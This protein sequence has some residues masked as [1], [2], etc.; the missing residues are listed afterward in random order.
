MPMRDG[1]YL[2][3]MALYARGMQDLDA[4]AMFT[5]DILSVI[6][7]ENWEL[8]ETLTPEDC[9][10]GD[11]AHYQVYWNYLKNGYEL[12]EYQDYEAMLDAVVAHF[13]QFRYDWI[14]RTEYS[15]EG[16]DEMRSRTVTDYTGSIWYGGKPLRG[17]ESYLKYAVMTRQAMELKREMTICGILEE[18]S[19]DWDTGT[20]EM[21]TALVN[22]ETGQAFLEEGLYHLEPIQKAEYEVPQYLS[23]LSKGV[24]V[25]PTKIPFGIIVFIAAWSLPD[26]VR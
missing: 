22:A 4:P 17:L 16:D 5:G 8:K 14:S 20:Y 12:Q 19:S 10:N 15:G 18:Y 2:W 9:P 23:F 7:D 25:K 1:K 11:K 24:P 26:C 3:P 21:P 13:L 6:M